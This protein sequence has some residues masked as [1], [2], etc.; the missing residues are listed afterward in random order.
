MNSLHYS[1]H[2]NLYQFIY[3]SL[4]LLK[5]LNY[6][7]TSSRHVVASKPDK[8][9]EIKGKINGDVCYFLTQT[10]IT[11]NII[12]V[13]SILC[14][15]DN[16]DYY[17]KDAATTAYSQVCAP[18]HTWAVRTAVYAGMYA[19]PTRDQLLQKLGETGESLT[20]LP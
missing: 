3:Q 9:M 13:V 10:P 2:L 16:R 5:Y 6:Y 17:L 20:M 19:L 8:S 14:Y 11:L 4:R 1:G 7:I 12:D 18:Y 15:V